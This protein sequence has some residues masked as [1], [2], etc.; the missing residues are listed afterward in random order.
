MDVADKRAVA[1]D[2]LQEH[3]L[4]RFCVR[5]VEQ[6][7]VAFGSIVSNLYRNE[8]NKTEY[9]KTV[10]IDLSSLNFVTVFLP[11]AISI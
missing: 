4:H 11:G 10:S 9:N 6:N 3:S 1:A 7:I 8:A 2:R 5:V